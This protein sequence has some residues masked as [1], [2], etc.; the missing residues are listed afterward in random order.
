MRTLH[1]GLQPDCI[2]ITGPNGAGKSLKAPLRQAQDGKAPSRK[3]GI[4]A[5][6]IGLYENDSS[7]IGCLTFSGDDQ[8]GT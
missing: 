4:F 5:A 6:V 2:I 8:L 7:P 3:A 1:D